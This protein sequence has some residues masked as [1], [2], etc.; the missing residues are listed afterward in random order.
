METLGTERYSAA[1]LRLPVVVGRLR[2]KIEAARRDGQG[3]LRTTARTPEDE[4]AWWRKQIVALGGDPR[5]G[6]P[7]ELSREWDAVIDAKLGRVI[8]THYAPSGEPE[9]VYEGE[10]EAKRLA[11]LVFERVLPLGTEL[12]RFISENDFSERYAGRHRRAVRRLGE[13]AKRHLGTDDVRRI[14]RREAGLFVDSLLGEVS[15][16]TANSL[17]SS[18]ATYWLWMGRRLG[19][20]GNPWREQQRRER[21]SEPLADKRP[22]TDEEVRALL[23]GD[24]YLTLHD[25]MRIAALSGMRISEMANLTVT[26]VLDGTFTIRQG[27]TAAAARSIPIHPDLTGII[28]RRVEGKPQGQRLFHELRASASRSKEVSAKASERFT[29]YRRGLGIDSRRPG[30]RQADADFHSFRRWFI[31]KA[32]QAGQPPHVISWVVGHAEGRKGMTLG[33][34]SAGPSE[35]QLRAVV[36]AVRLPEGT[37]VDS[38]GGPLMGEGLPSRR[39]PARVD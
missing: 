14:R 25:L 39:K 13:W 19:I 9:P 26:D 15:T 2:A 21:R 20:E 34:Y 1:V 29:A 8:D 7:D 11:D 24:T 37:P 30:Q 6:I 10:A 5:R 17:V 27:K 35:A 12:E 36:E 16:P 3:A 28:E 4:A 23:S 18:L 22:F 32:E 38:P 31:T 33:T